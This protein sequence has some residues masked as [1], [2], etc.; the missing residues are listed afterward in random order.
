MW[1]VQKRKQGL[2]MWTVY[3]IDIFDSLKNCL[4]LNLQIPLA[5]F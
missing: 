4:V 2:N 5:G 1:G 3:E